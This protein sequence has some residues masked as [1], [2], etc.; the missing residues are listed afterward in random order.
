VVAAPTRPTLPALFDATLLAA[1][2]IF[3]GDLNFRPSFTGWH[4]DALP[5]CFYAL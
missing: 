1:F 2:A 5:I 3:H 4:F